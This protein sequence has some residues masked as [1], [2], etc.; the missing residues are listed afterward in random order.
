MI[1]STNWLSEYVDLP[2][3]IRVLEERLALAGLNHE[4]T[5]VHG[6]DTAVEIEVTSNRPDC[7]GHLGVDREVAVLFARPLRIPD[8]RPREQGEDAAASVAVSITAPDLCPFYS[9]RVLRGVRVGPSPDWLV[10]RLEA[11]GVG[12]VNNV[13]D[14]TNYVMVECGQ[15]L[16]AFDLARI[17][18]GRIVVRTA[19]PGEGF[20]AINHRSYELPA[21][22]CVIADAE[23]PVALAGVMGGAATEITGDTRDVLLES[24]QFAPLAVRAAARGLVL[25][26]ASSFRFERV[27]DPESVDWA[28]R[29][30]AALI[31]EIAG[32]TLERG[33]VTAGTL[34]ATPSVVTLA[35]RRVEEVL[36]IHVARERQRAILTALGF[37]EVPVTAATT[38][39]PATAWR[40][41]SWRRDVLR[42]IDLV[43]EIGRIEG[44]DRVPE[45][46]PITA[47]PVEWSARETIVRRAGEAL[48][49]AGLCE[50]MTRSVVDARLEAWGSPW[51][52]SPPLVVAPPLVRGADRLRRTLLPSLLEARAV[53]GA[54]AAPHGDLFE[55]AR[56]YLTRSG[57]RPA[58]GPGPVD[59]PLLLGL[60]VAG[61][62]LH[63]KGVVAAALERLGL[64]EREECP[65]V[66]YRPIDLALFAPGRAAEIML[67]RP[68]HAPHRIGVIGEVATDVLAAFSIA[69]PVTAA[70]VRL[71]AVEWCV[72]AAVRLS[73]P[74]DFPPVGRDLNLVVDEAVPWAEVGS[75]LRA[76]I[77]DLLE[78]VTLVDVWRDD[79]RL[80]SG[81]KSL[82]VSCTLRSPHGTLS[83]EEAARVIDAA[84]AACGRRTGAILRG[85][86]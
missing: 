3:S 34:A 25:Q 9:A 74:S 13:V 61:G 66:A 42:D 71:D 10:R 38:A 8:P 2:D 15:P 51:G 50:A 62:F 70:E 64:T 83:G 44:Y 84:V 57:G 65:G 56:G 7:L 82:V 45:D 68:D 41:P 78:S 73:R 69:G 27:P 17:R 4:S 11:V 49:S 33:V 32:G 54:V 43:E 53:N 30:A 22:T 59:E 29:R 1:V 18:G 19:A 16:H 72:D 37:I 6:D 76:S 47:R 14:V 55:I 35:D 26:S 81:R 20:A 23:G 85:P 48:V 24:A 79:Q 5:R 46:V 75:A 86:G 63:G 31:L 21:G 36:G 40:V 28:S 77:G 52:E 80:G 39:A 12:S 67:A 58:I 60:T